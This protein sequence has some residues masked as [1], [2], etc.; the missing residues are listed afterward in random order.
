MSWHAILPYVPEPVR[1]ALTRA[2]AVRGG[3]LEELRIRAGRP[4][5]C[6]FEPEERWL[7]PS[8]WAPEP[9]GALVAGPDTVAVAVE[10][11]SQQSRYAFDEQ[12]RAGYITLPGGHRAGL[13]GRAVLEGGR[14]R[15]LAAPSGVNYRL[16]RAVAGAADGLLRAVASGR[17]RST[18]IVSPPRCGKTT[19]LRDLVRQL[20][21]GVA[22]AGIPPRKVSVVDERSELAG[23]VAGV[24][25]L[26]VGLRTDVLDGCPKAEG[27][28]WVLRA[29]SPEVVATDEIGRP[30]DGPAVAEALG[31]GV[32]VL[33]TAHA[34][35][36]GDLWRRPVLRGLVAGGAFERIALFSRR[37]GPGTLEGVFD[38]GGR[39]VAGAGVRSPAAAASANGALRPAG[40]PGGRPG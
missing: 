39:P 30:E 16:A 33:A 6:Q 35:D 7:G 14:V 28:L 34:A 27:L 1:Q 24:P 3:P 4:V 15:T 36:L 37:L 26:P 31:A 18:L 17:V 20:S 32:A 21:D 23:C 2:M 8:G 22:A 11:L 13:T 25:Q 40:F 10:L 38:A 12:L 19:V 29:L 5:A 9:G